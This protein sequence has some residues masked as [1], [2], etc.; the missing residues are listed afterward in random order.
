MVNEQI[1]NEFMAKMI[2]DAAGISTISGAM[3]KPKKINPRRLK[4]T[5]TATTS[6]QFTVSHRPLTLTASE[7]T[8]SVRMRTNVRRLS[9]PTSAHTASGL[10]LSVRLRRSVRRTSQPLPPTLMHSMLKRTPVTRP[11]TSTSGTS[12]L[13][14][15]TAKRRF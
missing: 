10:E 1:V 5:T 13:P 8:P 11:S 3:L 9:A 15:S 14:R 6:L 4:V 7:S 2:V 12:A